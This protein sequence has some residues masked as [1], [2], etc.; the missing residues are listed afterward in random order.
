MIKLFTFRGQ[1]PGEKQKASAQPEDEI[2]DCVTI[3]SETHTLNSFRSSSKYS[4]SITAAMT[5]SQPLF[6]LIVFQP[7]FLYAA[8]KLLNLIKG[9]F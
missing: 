6:S 8:P 1:S 5:G 2:S 3:F 4:L 9:Q 7:G